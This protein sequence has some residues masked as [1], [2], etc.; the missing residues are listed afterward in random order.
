MTNISITGFTESFLECFLRNIFASN[1]RNFIIT[2]KTN[3][4]STFTKCQRQ[5]QTVRGLNIHLANLITL[6][7]LSS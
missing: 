6:W 2:L 3:M 1:L 4:F 5:F 7:K